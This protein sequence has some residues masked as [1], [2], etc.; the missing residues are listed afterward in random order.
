L[1]TARGFGRMADNESW[2][3]QEIEMGENGIVRHWR[4]IVAKPFQQGSP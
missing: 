3:E 1:I 2:L 4:R